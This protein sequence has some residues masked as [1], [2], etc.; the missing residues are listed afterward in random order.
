MAPPP[1][2]QKKQKTKRETQ[3]KLVEVK[4]T[5][6]RNYDGSAI[7]K[8]FYAPS[9]KQALEKA[10]AYKLALA[11]NT[12]TPT[13]VTFEQWANNWLTTYK[14]GSVRDVTLERSYKGP[15]DKHI[16]PYFG[17]MRLSEIRPVHVQ[18]FFQA[19]ASYSYSQQHK[20]K[21]IL[22]DIFDRALENDLISKNPAKRIKLSKSAD[23]RIKAKQAYT[24]DQAQIFVSF[25]RRHPF[26]VGPIILI[27]TGMRLGELLA[28][29]LA[30]IDETARV[31]HVRQSVS[32]T[33]YGLEYHA[34][35]TRKSV[36]DIPYREDLD[37]ILKSVPRYTR[38]Q[39]GKVIVPHQYLITNR[40]GGG[41]G[42]HSWRRQYDKFMDDFIDFCKTEGH[43]DI[44]RLTPHELRHSFGSILYERGVDIVTIS[45]LMGHA[46]IDITTRLYVH[47]NADLKR[48]AISRGV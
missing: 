41:C 18:R 28:L 34:C 2:K 27:K 5:V 16:I 33:R 39:Q 20:L 29:E 9:R 17:K 38:R 32:E 7:R 1:K 47:D 15:L 8:S 44:P 13:T 23:D 21:L 45:K 24:Y 36:R 43:N 48:Q 46:S 12:L 22:S 19:K 30:A 42:P 3:S 11:T 14:E 10:D 35:K 6:G 4:V 25:A 31:I 26:G 37:D 40:F